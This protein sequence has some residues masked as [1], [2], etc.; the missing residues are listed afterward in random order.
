[1]RDLLMISGEFLRNGYWYRAHLG[2][3][4]VQ[5]FRENNGTYSVKN[6]TRWS[7]CVVDD[8]GSLIKVSPCAIQ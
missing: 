6:H 8:F 7:V 2:A 4:M 3:S 5:V 1:M